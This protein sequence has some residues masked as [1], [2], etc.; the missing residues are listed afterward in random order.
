MGYALIALAIVTQTA[1]TLGTGT[2][3]APGRGAIWAS[4]DAPRPLTTDSVQTVRLC[5]PR[6]K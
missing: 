5:R 2:A 1:T 6:Q 4:C 3:V